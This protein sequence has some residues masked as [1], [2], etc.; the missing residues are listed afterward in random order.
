MKKIESNC[1]ECSQNLYLLKKTGHAVCIN[2]EC[3]MHVNSKEK[4]EEEIKVEIENT[5]IEIIE[6]KKEIEEEII[7]DV[8]IVHQGWQQCPVCY[9][10]G[11]NLTT[12]LTDKTR[13]SCTVC[14]GEKIISITTG[15]PPLK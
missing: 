3:A 5:E 2:K 14:K 6:H 9:G 11:L 7:K 15:R 13:V 4:I 12:G 1:P 10:S 8:E